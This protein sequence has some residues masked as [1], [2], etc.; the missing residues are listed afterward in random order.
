MIDIK[1]FRDNPELVAQASANKG[2]PIDKTKLIALDQNRIA[3]LQ[4]IEELRAQ[5][6]ELASAAKSGGKPTPEQIEQGK[7]LKVKLAAL[8]TQA[9]AVEAEF[10]VLFKKVANLPL[11]QV[12]VGS[13]E[14]EN[15]VIRTVGEP[16]AF[17]FTPKSH[18]E[19]GEVRGWLDKERATKVSGARFMYVKGDLVRLQMAIVNFVMSTLSDDKL[20]ARLIAD[21]NLK[22]VSKPFV[23]VLPPAM[24]RTEV[25]DAMDRLEPRD[26][27]Y[28]VG[29]AEDELWLQGSAEHTLGSMYMNET[30]P[31]ENLPIRYLGYL[32]SFRRE[33]GTYGK[34]MEGLIRL[35]QFDKLE[36]EVFSDA[37]TAEDEHKL[38]LALQE[39]LVASLGLPYRVLQKCTYDIGKPN[40]SGFDI[41]VWFPSQNKYRETHTADY[42]S[43]YQ[44]RRT[45]TR[46]KTQDGTRFVH[47]ND[48]TAFALGRIMAAVIENYQ[49][50][51]GTINIPPILVKF[52]GTDKLT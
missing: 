15:V 49:T 25:F 48:A 39:Y 40:A 7:E 13:S 35:H 8:E 11:K 27:R 34:D 22:I 52:L 36:M 23:P 1:I 50:E 30:L 4:Q 16:T 31:S 41:E 19:I 28:N 5:R 14:E 21:N 46:Y 37:E 33:A 32:T 2:Y 12:P 20:I 6:N 42:M 47:T 44:T 17:A 3:L 10:S 18:A 43:D 24:I 29:P 45:N 9:E 26:D 51:D 38:L